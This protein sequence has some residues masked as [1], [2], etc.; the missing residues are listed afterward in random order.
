MYIIVRK[1]FLFLGRSTLI[2]DK[3]NQSPEYTLKLI[4]KS[5]ILK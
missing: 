4:I 5:L 3:Q 2:K 1:Y